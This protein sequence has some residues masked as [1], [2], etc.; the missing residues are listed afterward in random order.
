MGTGG[1]L[2]GQGRF[3]VHR[4]HYPEKDEGPGGAPPGGSLAALGGF[5]KETDLGFRKGSAR[6]AASHVAHTS[7]IGLL[8][9]GVEAVEGRARFIGQGG[10]RRQ[11]LVGNVREAVAAGED[12]LGGV[13]S[14][15]LADGWRR[16]LR[17]GR[18]GGLGLCRRRR[19]LGLDG[20]RT[21]LGGEGALGLARRGVPCLVRLLGLASDGA[22]CRAGIARREGG[23]AGT[24]STLTA[25]ALPPALDVALGAEGND[26]ASSALSAGASLA[27][28]AT[29]ARQQA[30]VR[31]KLRLLYLEAGGLTDL[32]CLDC[33]HGLGAVATEHDALA[34]VACATARRAAALG[35]GA[36][37]EKLGAI[38]QT[39]GSVGALSAGTAAGLSL[40]GENDAGEEESEEDRT[41]HGSRKL[42]AGQRGVRFL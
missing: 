19:G 30:V 39:G 28:A 40:G 21:R 6:I 34:I 10:G 31:R 20:W 23:E 7:A 35:V 4:P 5:E 15:R 38:A 26:S 29:T 32:A 2:W 13:A 14:R 22:R 42:S 18:G 25:R 11:A 36:S 33:G 12:T 9:A 27:A 17:A 3:C 37:E 16:G 1:D 8:L 24:F 41:G